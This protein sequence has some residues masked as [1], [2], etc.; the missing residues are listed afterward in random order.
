[1]RLVWGGMCK[2][3]GAKLRCVLA[4]LPKNPG[5]SSSCGLGVFPLPL[6]SGLQPQPPLI[7]SQQV[8][9]SD[10]GVCSDSWQPGR[11]PLLEPSTLTKL[12]DSAHSCSQ[13]NEWRKLRPCAGHWGWGWGGVGTVCWCPFKGEGLLSPRHIQLLLWWKV[14]P[15]PPTAC[16]LQVAG[17]APALS[18][19]I[20]ATQRAVSL[21]AGR[22][23]LECWHQT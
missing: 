8:V 15:T 12:Q 14:T 11:P 9:S 23:S 16:S 4:S 19:L 13:G 3:M 20:Q 22:V 1:M 18:R 5:R 6:L 17:L 7:L 2:A 21:P 10:L